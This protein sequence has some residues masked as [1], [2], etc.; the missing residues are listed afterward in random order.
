MS[1]FTTPLIVTPLDN[2]SSWKLVEPFVYEEG[3]LGSEQ[4][5][6]IPTGFI[7]DFASVPRIFWNLISPWGRHGKA[8]VLHDFLYAT[9]QFTRKR[10]DDILLEAMGVLGVPWIDRWTIY[11][12][13]RAGGWLA[14]AEHRKR[15]RARVLPVTTKEAKK[16]IVAPPPEVI[17][18]QE[19]KEKK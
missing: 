14:W 6:E 16:A 3:G 5:I 7:T 8:A 11:L 12:G 2:G 18:Q 1:S 4:K 9:G 10:S 17:K 13:V 19:D 15:D